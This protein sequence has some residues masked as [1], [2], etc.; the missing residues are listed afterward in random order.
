MSIDRRK[1]VGLSASALLSAK[2]ATGTAI[3]AKP[4]TTPCMLKATKESGFKINALMTTGD[5][6]N[7]YR[8]PGIMDGMGA[9]DWNATTVRL[10]TNHELPPQ[11]GYPWQ[12]DNGTE[13]LG[14]RVSWFDIDKTTRRITDAGSAIR[15]IRDRRGEV[16]TQPV[17][18]HEHR[19]KESNKGLNNLCS[20]QGYTAGNFGFQDDIFFTHE[21]VSGQEDH[22]HGGSVWAMEVRTGVLWALPELG[23]GSWENVTAIVTCNHRNRR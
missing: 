1:F 4:A 22:P 20:A 12:L 16:V 8:P 19:N 10:L 13:L 7:G 17:Q 23:R 15:K 3:A 14:A 11:D 21:E 18:V 6:I 9:W 2:Y 5:I